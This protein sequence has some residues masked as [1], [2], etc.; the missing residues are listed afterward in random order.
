VDAE[1]CRVR[2]ALGAPLDAVQ[3]IARHHEVGWDDAEPTG[4]G[5]PPR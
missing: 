3:V 5:E 1:L 2:K 4:S